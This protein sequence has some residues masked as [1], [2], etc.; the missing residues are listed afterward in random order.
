MKNLKLL[1]QKGYP[2]F[3]KK[4]NLNE[5]DLFYSYSNNKIKN[6]DCLSDIKRTIRIYEL[7]VKGE[8]T[9]TFIK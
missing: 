5:A 2:T 9:K 7:S 8:I 3:S 6:I 4:Q 1:K